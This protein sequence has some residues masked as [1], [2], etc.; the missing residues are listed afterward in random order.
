MPNA[1]F[2]N[3]KTS[4][5]VSRVALASA[6][7]AVSLATFQATSAS[8]QTPIDF[9]GSFKSNAHTVDKQSDPDVAILDDG[10]FLIVWHSRNQLGIP[11][12]DIFARHYDADGTPSADDL[13]I[14][15]FTTGSQVTP[16][17]TAT[18]DGYLVVWQD[19]RG[20]DGDFLSGRFFDA[21]GAGVGSSFEILSSD[22]GAIKP[23]VDRAPDGS[24]VVVWQ[25]VAAP[26]EYEIRGR[27]LSS[28]G[29]SLGDPFVV[30]DDG[31][32]AVDDNRPTVAVN[33]RGDFLVTWH[34]PTPGNPEIRGRFYTSDGSPTGDSVQLNQNTAFSQSDSVVTDTPDGFVVAWTNGFADGSFGAV[35]ARRFDRE[36]QPVG[37]QFQVNT[38]TTHNQF[39][40]TIAA[41]AHG[42]VVVAWESFGQDGDQHGLYGQ[43][44]DP[45]GTAVGDEFQINVTMIDNQETPRLAMAPSG[46]FVVAWDRGPNDQTSDVY[47]RRF[48]LDLDNDGVAD[49]FDNCPV[50]ANADQFDFDMDGTGA[51]CDCNDDQPE[52]QTIDL[53]GVCGGDNSTCG[54]FFDDFESG[55]DGAWAAVIP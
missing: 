37:G 26:F 6:F 28:T 22:Y 44:Y 5:A 45:D 13:E 4:F 36:G 27:R 18:D 19:D 41:D 49:R 30:S 39:Q 17:I 51:V 40:P 8:A 23:D 34:G 3:T 25:H 15:D 55:D 42:R 32:P 54:I 35:A 16:A 21:E 52:A 33:Q 31:D 24:F 46:D 14:N 43:Q 38:Y 53:C 48:G 29:A 47:G 11:G 2:D 20:L 9:G 1:F 50:D 10:S 7:L 12:F